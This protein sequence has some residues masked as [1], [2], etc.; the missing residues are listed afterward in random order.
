MSLRSFAATLAALL[1]LGAAAAS[2]HA[3]EF[4]DSAGRRATLPDRI[5]RVMP[6]GPTG[7]VL[8]YALA[9]KKLLGWTR[10]Y[11]HT[12]LPANAAR[13]PMI[14]RLNAAKPT[15]NAD[16]I[17][18]LRPD[19]IIDAG[20]VTPER[21]ALAD[22]LQAESGVPY[23]LVDDS[24]ARMPEMLRSVGIMLGAAERGEDLASYAERALS[25]LRGRL[26]IRPAEKRWRVYYG[27]GP[28]GLQTAPPGSPVGETIEAAGAINVAAAP[29][30]APRVEV[31]REELLGWDPDIIIALEPGFYTALQ[32]DPGWRRLAAVRNKRFY[33]A[34]VQ[35]FG[36]ID[37]PPG[38]NRLIGLY[39]LSA[40]FY[41]D[42]AQGDLRTIIR[43]F[44]DK[45]YA[46]K[47]NDKAMEGL[48]RHTGVPPGGTFGTPLAGSGTM[49]GMSLYGAPVTP[50]PPTQ[51]LMP[52]ALPGAVPGVPPPGRRGLPTPSTTTPEPVPAL[53]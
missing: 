45:F 21:A 16:T 47:L 20:P 36:W 12:Y 19:V 7:E 1:T 30:R 35:P 43:E 37:E 41:P 5:D 38:V 48:V 22:R 29:G 17:R 6:A 50:M 46:A 4:L 44:Y 24:I 2:G 11:K 49:S 27:R 32:R 14:G 18:R 23:L 15:A 31:T 10:P 53:R 26:L 51:G 25:A 33:L 34:P 42:A 52:G 8:I 40:L 9:P 13:L 28:D 39:W 3:R